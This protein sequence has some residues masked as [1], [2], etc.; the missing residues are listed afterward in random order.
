MSVTGSSMWSRGWILLALVAGGAL[1]ATGPP[2]QAH[3]A[4]CKRAGQCPLH[5]WMRDRLKAP[6]DAGELA[7]LVSPLER[8]EGLSPEPSW[9]DGP[10]G[11]KALARDGSEAARAG[12]EAG[13]RATCEACHKAWKW[14]YRKRFRSRPLP[15]NEASPE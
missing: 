14:K 3:G 10:K 2:A 7:K 6:L 15:R 1:G 9:N 8:L 13:V 4:A 5:D 11:W 12:D